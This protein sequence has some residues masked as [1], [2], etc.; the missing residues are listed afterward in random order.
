MSRMNADSQ[1][2]PVYKALLKANAECQRTIFSCDLAIWGTTWVLAK[3]LA[4]EN[5]CRAMATPTEFCNQTL[6][7]H[8]VDEMPCKL[9]FTENL[10]WFNKYL[11]TP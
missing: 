10:R 4:K 9:D 11:T 7:K 1:W 5:C 2:N 8:E 6:F 3:T